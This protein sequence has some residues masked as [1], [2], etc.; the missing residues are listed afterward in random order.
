MGVW[1]A[2]KW[3]F[4]EAAKSPAQIAHKWQPHKAPKW[5][6]MGPCAVV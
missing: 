3:A 6:F 2:L 4:M 5:P 1:G